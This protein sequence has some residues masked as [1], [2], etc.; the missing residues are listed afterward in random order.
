VADF[1]HRFHIHDI[2]TPSGLGWVLFNNICYL[3]VVSINRQP[4]IVK[5]LWA[6]VAG[7]PII[8]CVW[9][10]FGIPVGYNGDNQSPSLLILLFPVTNPDLPRPTDAINQRGGDDL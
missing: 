9:M 8:P 6:T 4:D 2:H 5:R 1:K 7:A 10:D 3:T